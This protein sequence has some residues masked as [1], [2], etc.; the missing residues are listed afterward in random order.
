MNI[1]EKSDKKEN[2]LEKGFRKKNGIFSKKASYTLSNL[3][4]YFNTLNNELQIDFQFESNDLPKIPKE[5]PLLIVSNHP[6]GIVDILL[7]LK[8]LLPIRPELKIVSNSVPRQLAK[9][10]NL[11]LKHVDA[12]NPMKRNSKPYRA[13]YEHLKKN[14]ALVVFPAGDTVSNKVD[15]KVTDP[16]W[17]NTLIKFIKNS[18]TPVVP[19][20]F[21][22]PN[23]N[24]FNV[25]FP[26]HPMLKSLKLPL[27]LTF[28]K[29]RAI[30]MRIGNAISPNEVLEFE[31][32]EKFGRFLRAK[33]YA[34]GSPLEV[35]KFFLS[36]L[37][38]AAK[39]EPIIDP[40][41]PEKILE[42]VNRVKESY[43]LFKSENYS[44]ICAPTIEIPN[45]LTEIGRLR[46]TTF[47]DVGE[48]TNRSID[49]D[50]FDLYYHQLF[51]WDDAGNK[52]VGAYRVGKGKDIL[53]IHG[54][55]GFYILSLFKISPDFQDTLIQ[56]IELGRS[57]IVKE[58]QRKPMPLFLLWK[59]ILYFLIKNPEYRYLIGPVSISNRF[60]QFSKT[61]IIKF[62]KR[63]YYNYELARLIKPRKEFKVLPKYDTDIVLEK[64][65]DD[66]SKLDK[67]ISD[68]EITNYRMPV[69][70]KKYLKLNAKIIG[71]N[72]DPLFNDA[73]DGLI[74]LD[75]YEVPYDTITALSK[76]IN[77]ASILDRFT[78]MEKATHL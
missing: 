60:S 3:D 41:N 30:Q 77:D 40:V 65:Q 54:I 23:T 20:Y 44:V 4:D 57:F 74:V 2:I 31:D 7:L 72:I 70:L 53:K 39:E 43:L 46:E 12:K 17:K 26:I 55:K 76:E 59:G 25:L 37:R 52:M 35:K 16:Q 22:G 10:S 21:H 18:G 9:L 14:Y 51:I 36:G 71:F 62:L 1:T 13:M 45:V 38:R 69:L 32:V 61:L 33:L 50:E 58:Y 34:L 42:E 15:S 68:V 19:I 75:L 28:R 47:R 78:D 63:N 73:L 49:I 6:F 64:M 5:G 27:D 8:Y 48:G 11:F 56:S 66:V 29:N 67:L 24:I